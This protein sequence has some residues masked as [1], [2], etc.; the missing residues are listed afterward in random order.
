MAEQRTRVRLAVELDIESLE[1]T[2]ELLFGFLLSEM[3]EAAEQAS[4]A[5][6]L[7]DHPKTQR[8]QSGVSYSIRRFASLMTF[9]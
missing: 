2:L 8:C 7:V 9:A 6:F 4:A 1:L 3:T 5:V